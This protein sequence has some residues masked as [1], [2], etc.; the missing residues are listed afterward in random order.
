MLSEAASAALSTIST[1]YMTHVLEMNAAEIGKVFLPVFVAGIPGTPSKLGGLVGVLVLNPLRPVLLCLIIFVINT[2]LTALTLT[3]PE[4]KNAMYGFAAVWGVCLS[5]LHPTH[6]SLYRTIIP[7]GQESELMGIYTFSGS[8]MA[9]LPPFVFSF[10]NE[11]GSEWK[12]VC[13]LDWLR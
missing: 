12:R 13:Q 11:I 7:R 3:G 9:R 1:T 5:W 4:S 8:V 2:N 10:L 6:A